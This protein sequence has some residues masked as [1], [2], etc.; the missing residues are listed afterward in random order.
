MSAPPSS[1]AL[2]ALERLLAW[3][4]SLHGVPAQGRVTVRV[5]PSDAYYTPFAPG[6]RVSIP[7]VA[8]HRDGDS[9]SCP[10]DALYARLPAVRS[11]VAAQAGQPVRLT[12]TASPPVMVAGG[13]VALAGRLATL[14]G[15]P[16]SGAPIELQRLGGGGALTVLVATTAADGSWTAALTL[17]QNAVLGA[18]HRSRPASVAA[19]AFIAVTPAVT[20]T[21]DATAPLQLSGSVSPAKR[22]VTV[23]LYAVSG[24]RRR[25]V[26]HK[27]VAVRQGQFVATLRRPKPGHYVARVVTDADAASAA[28]SSPDVPVIV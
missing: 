7:R 8:G 6:Q 24:G 15:R 10:G 22:A 13:T 1:A 25:L 12:I 2:K 4:L 18:L 23:E 5:N 26:R 28:G 17:T 20:L 11:A 3:K 27:R 21:V 16:V 14:T 19:P 9:T